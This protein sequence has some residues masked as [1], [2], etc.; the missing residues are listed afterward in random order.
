MKGWSRPGSSPSPRHGAWQRE[1]GKE[2]VHAEGL[3][4]VVVGTRIE[5]RTLSGSW[6]GPTAR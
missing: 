4:H 6:F 3:S 2:L 5:G 1:A